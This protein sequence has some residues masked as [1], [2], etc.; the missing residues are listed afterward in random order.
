MGGKGGPGGGQGTK[1]AAGGHG[2]CGWFGRRLAVREP[3]AESTLPA[4]TV[5]LANDAFSSNQAIGGPGG[6]GGS[7]GSGGKG[8]GGT[9]IPGLP[10]GPG[11]AGGAGGTASG[12]AIYLAA[13]TL[14]LT[15]STLQ[16]NSARRRRRRSGRC[17]RSRNECGWQHHGHLRRH[18][19]D[20]F[21]PRRTWPPKEDQAATA[22]PAAPVATAA[23]GGV[24]VA[25]GSLTFL[26]STLAANQAV[27]GQGGVGGRGGT[28]GFRMGARLTSLGLGF[29][30]I[31]QPAGNGAN[32]RSGWI[33]LR[34][35][36]QRGR[37]NRRRARRHAERQRRSGGPG[38]HRRT[39]RQR[40][41]RRAG[42]FARS[43]NERWQ[44]A[45]VEP[46]DGGTGGG[47]TATLARGRVAN[48]GNGGTGEGGGLYVSGG[49]LTLTNATIAANSVDAGAAGI[50]GKGGKAGSGTLTGGVG[51]R[52]FARRLVR[53]RPSMSTVPT[54]DLYNSTIALNT[55]AGSGSGGGVVQAAGTVTAVSTLFGGNGT[56]DYSG[57]VTA[58]DSLFQTEP[59]GTLSGTGNLV[60]VDPLLDPNGLQNNGGPTETIAL[61]SL[62]PRHRRGNESGKPLC[63]SARLRPTHRRA[64]YRYRRLPVQR[65]GRHD[66]RRPL[67]LQAVTVTGANAGSLNPYTFTITFSDNVA[68]AAASLSGP[69]V[70]VLPPARPH[71]SPR[72]SR[73]RLQ[74]A[75]PTP[76]AMPRRS[77]SRTR[78]L[79]PGGSWTAADNGVYTI[80]L[81]G[82]SVID[83][84]GNA[85]AT[86]TLGTFSVLGAS[87]ATVVV[88]STLAGST[89]GQSVSFTVDGQRQRVDTHGNRS[90]PGRWHRLWLPGHALGW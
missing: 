71:R 76:M 53:R 27:G 22:G 17:R 36:N 77:S 59:T 7:G 78:S 46:A 16:S 85:V 21:Q 82:A 35:R 55:Q 20:S 43:W 2:R 24:F 89:Y 65:L 54:L 69:V 90:V 56:V 39:R 62:E 58:T 64:W 33:G 40:S 5:I 15:A 1:S 61:E 86:G 68:I 70:Q 32:R 30:I 80:T 51:R 34:R 11:G 47:G 10:G 6:T 28:G 79:P 83:L 37:R 3:V 9:A 60:G 75:A 67:R 88:G 29:G 63:R 38:G 84:A 31:G 18:R 13:G 66:R 87:S 41:S 81:G 23:G 42:K 4:A 26:N 12:G 25:G 57:N 50:G 49:S 72:L 45:A 73:A 48:G 44:L 52:R 14:T 19:L 8:S 74:S